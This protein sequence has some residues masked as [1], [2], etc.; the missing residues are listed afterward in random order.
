MIFDYCVIGGGIVGL[1]TAMRLLETYPGSSLILLEKEVALGK[2]QTGH[3]SGVIH[4]GIYYPPGSLK[5]ELCRKGADATK[6]F[7]QENGIRFDVCGKLLVA[8]SALEVQRMEALHERSKQNTIE[9]HSFSEGE[10][11]EREPNISGLGALFVPST[12]IVSYADVCQAMGRRIKAL[13]GEI[14][15]STRV[16]GIR[17]ARDSVDISSVGE[18]WQAKQLVVCGGLQSDRLAVLAGLSIEHRIVPFRG[19]Y[20]RLPASKN[21]IVRHLIY[22]VP[23]PALPFLGVHLTRMIDGSVTVG[24]NA[25]IG[26]AREGYPRLSFNV[27]DMAD[28][29]LFPGFWKTVF[30]NRGSA[31]AELRNSLW[32]PGYLEECRKYCPSLDLTDLLPHE[33][34]IRA[35]AVR[36]DGA[37]IHDF[38]F[39]QTE[40]MLHVCNAPSPAATSAIPIA[41]M[42]VGRMADG[43]RRMPAN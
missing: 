38:L 36:K 2:H 15:L 6:A 5:A 37:L 9:V 42:I 35:Q 20:Y 27:L 23:D 18:N 25:V 39:A 26:F 29:A 31:L 10:L 13:G 41:E 40:R 16:T 33:A 4:A 17:E 30:A 11:K 8:T 24:P 28:Y 14:R 7:C 34:G 21:D 22:P 32:K 19:E 3:N 43:R 12:G 1:A